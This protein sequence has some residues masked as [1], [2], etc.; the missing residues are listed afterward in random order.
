MSEYIKVPASSLHDFLERVLSPYQLLPEVAIALTTHLVEANLWGMDSHGLQ[1]IFGYVKSLESGRIHPQ[2]Q[3]KINC[4][5][6]AMIRIDG[7]A[8]P[9][10]YTGKLAM[11]TAITQARKLGMAV[12]GVN[13][14]NHFGMAGYYTKMA[15]EAGMVGF[16]TSDTNVVDLAPYGGRIAKIGNNPISVGIPTGTSHP[17]VLDMAAGAVSG[18]KIKHFKYQGLAIPA[19]WGITAAGQPTQNP[20]EV[21]V[22][23]P[24]SYKGA[25][26]A[27]IADLLCGPMLGTAAAMFK[28]KAIHDRANGTGHFFW[29]LDIAAWTDKEEFTQQVQRAIA[30]L[31]ETPRLDDKQPIYY[32]GELEAITRDR[33]LLEG[34]PIPRSLVDEL[35]NV[36]E[37]RDIVANFGR[38]ES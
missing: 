6:P 33:R 13:N 25:G 17:V 8:A 34:I 9:G 35:K 26:L 32:P 27:L 22:N 12:V 31:K 3:I 14:S 28:Q 24:A 30:S 16:A 11:E 5:R 23:L 18:G 7:G 1:Q 10:Q 36:Y 20:Q 19:G 4:D 15:A 29:V 38:E 21:A 37:I 2:P